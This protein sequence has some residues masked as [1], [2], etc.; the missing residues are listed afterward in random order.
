[1]TAA[2]VKSKCRRIC[3]NIGV[4]PDGVYSIEEP[5]Y[6][7]DLPWMVERMKTVQKPNWER[8]VRFIYHPAGEPTF[9]IQT[10]PPWFA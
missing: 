1:M 2:E 9:S 8:F 10:G 5:V 3:A 7:W 6:A 4:D